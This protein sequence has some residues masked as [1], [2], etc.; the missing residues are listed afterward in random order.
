MAF[1]R[2]VQGDIDPAELGVTYAHAITGSC[3]FTATL[4]E[5]RIGDDVR[6]ALFVH[7]PARAFAFAAGADSAT[8]GGTR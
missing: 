4:A 8:D 3:E 5:A 1:V 6:H 2:T 7:N